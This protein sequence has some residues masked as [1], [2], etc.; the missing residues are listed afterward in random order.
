MSKEVSI[1]L[2]NETIGK[3][4][5]LLNMCPTSFK[6]V[7][8]KFINS[9]DDGEYVSIETA[10]PLG[11]TIFS[12]KVDVSGLGLEIDSCMAVRLPLNK[13]ITN[14]IFGGNFDRVT[15]SKSRIVATDDRKE[16]VVSMFNLED[17]DVLDLYFTGEEILEEVLND[18][19]MTDVENIKFKMPNSDVIKELGA[20]VDT[21]SEYDTVDIKVKTCNNINIAVK[22]FTDNKIKYQLVIDGELTN[23][24]E[25]VYNEKLINTLYD[26]NKL[27]YDDI[28]V[29]LSSIVTIFTIHDTGLIASIALTSKVNL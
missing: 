9:S 28:D 24:F 18:T 29:I 12:G 2:S 26:I 16:I 14:F 22:D 23:P 4:S 25:T 10:N 6:F 8:M 17:A 1:E 11:D 20:C 19:G 7:P 13:V 5:K 21:L 27:P 3:I 15:V